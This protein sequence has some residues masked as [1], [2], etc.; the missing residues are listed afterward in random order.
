MRSRF[1]AALI[2]ASLVATLV[3]V[4]SA[5]AHPLGNFTINHYIGLTVEAERIDIEYVMDMAEIPAY[6]E[7]ANID[8][9]GNDVVDL[10]EAAGYHTARCSA[11]RTDL[12]LRLN[13]RKTVLNVA[14]SNLEFPPGAGGLR[15]L[16]LTCGYQTEGLSLG[17]GVRIDLRNDL[18]PKRLAWS[19]IVVISKGVSL[20]GD[21]AT[22]S[23]SNQLRT[24][25]DDLLSN[26]LNQRQVSLEVV[27]TAGNS[28]TVIS[29]ASVQASALPASGRDDAFTRLIQ[30]QDPS[31]PATLLALLF[32]IAWGAMHAMT[33]G[34]GKTVVG[35]YLIGSRGTVR[36]ALFLGL[37]TTITHTAGVFAL[38]LVTLFASQFILPERLYPWLSVLS[39]LSLI[40]LGV[41]LFLVRIRHAFPAL[42]PCR[43]SRHQS[44]DRSSH[45]HL[46]ASAVNGHQ[47]QPHTHGHDHD[48]DQD[49][50]KSHTQQ[51]HSHQPPGA[52]GSP[53]S[54]RNLLALGISGGLLPCPSALIVLLS[55]IALGRVG[56]GIA[57]VIA[58]SL[59]LAGVLSAIGL[60]FVYARRFFQRIP[61]R[62]RVLGILPAL[63]AA[64]VVLI[65]VGITLKALV[66]TGLIRL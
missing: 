52:D 37:T 45:G 28:S 33:P 12:T 4:P 41:S 2:L 57:L 35:A 64:F 29:P 53:V 48:H 42:Q 60:L 40:V 51:N 47:D 63:S 36:H 56:F 1:R 49:S 10:S 39:G 5:A 9:D 30:L 50:P 25:P 43:G 65:G 22:T 20:Q 34:H 11:L 54:W 19:E 18:Y 26:P 7:L 3:V 58:F 32:A 27:P 62:G 21:F 23:P 13:G 31:L 59:G 14:T 17:A 66:E 15:T 8:I 55:A 61:A 24:Y 44:A 6:Q 38:G 46:H 16:R